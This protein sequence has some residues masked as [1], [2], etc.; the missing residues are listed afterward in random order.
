MQLNL[1]KQSIIHR[2]ATQQAHFYL[3]TTLKLLFFF[4]FVLFFTTVLSCVFVAMTDLHFPSRTF[5]LHAHCNYR[6]VSSRVV[7][8]ISR[9]KAHQVKATVFVLS[10]ALSKTRKIKRNKFLDCKELCLFFFTRTRKC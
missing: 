4:F 6:V 10:F 2:E 5:W 8:R 9:L 3:V 7:N 1:E